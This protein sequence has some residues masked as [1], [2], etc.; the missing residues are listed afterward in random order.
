MGGLGIIL[1]RILPGNWFKQFKVP[2]T[3]ADQDCGEDRMR[4]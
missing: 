2:T 3:P 4:Q 1:G